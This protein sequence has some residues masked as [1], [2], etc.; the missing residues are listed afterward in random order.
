M[1][2]LQLAFSPPKIKK[3][4]FNRLKTLWMMR[5]SL[6]APV[7]A[8][9][10]L[11]LGIIFGFL[12]TELSLA[13]ALVALGGLVV[14]YAAFYR[15]EWIILLMLVVYATIIDDRSIPR[16]AKR[17][18]AVEVCLLLLLGLI[19]IRAFSKSNRA[20]GG[21][22]HTPL[23]WPVFLFFAVSTV[24]FLNAKYNLGTNTIIASLSWRNLSL[25]MI[26]FAVTNFI[27]TR[28]QLMILIGSMFV[29]A[30]VVAGLMIVQQFLGPGVSIIPSKEEVGTATAL[31]QELYD[32]ARVTAPGA[33]IVY[34]MLLPAF[35]LYITPECLPARKWLLLIVIVLFPVAIAFTFTRSMWSGAV[36]SCVLFIL[37]ARGNKN[38]VLLLLALVIAAS[39]LVPLINAYFPRTETIVEALSLRVGS[40]FAGDKLIEDK[41]TQWR[42]R[43]N[44]QVIPT[45]KKY[46]IWGVGPG[47][48]YRAPWDKGDAYTH[49]IHN[50][51]LYL[52][53]DLGIVGFL[54]FLW[55]SIVFLVRGLLAW[56]RLQDPVLKSIIIGFTLSYVAV[57]SSSGTSP[58]FF[59]QNYILLI[60]VMLGI[61]EVVIRLGRQS[62][63]ENIGERK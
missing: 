3:F 54:P 62:K 42:L 34:V 17:F 12:A 36:L 40:L 1:R 10:A 47:G 15:P 2:D 18:T 60:G 28:R 11:I 49:Y 25:Y 50:G 48:E 5:Q 39:L 7:L 52:L 59:E 53:V 13:M 24:S 31:G 6:A 33:A 22:V 57:L 46:P 19:I 38:F 16:I 29:M 58:R 44:E 27:R 23:D 30:A 51:Y 45:I 4:L 55:F 35:V 9:T 56:Y 32:V 20:E 41:S 63:L 43:E 37:I 26:F 8:I 61:N 14:V 21:F